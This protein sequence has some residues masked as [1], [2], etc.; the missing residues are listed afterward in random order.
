M[1]LAIA[2]FLAL[3]AFLFPHA[4][5]ANCNSLLDPHFTWASN[6]SGVVVA[7]FTR[8]LQNGYVTYGSSGVGGGLSYDS[9]TDTLRSWSTA[10]YVVD[11]DEMLTCSDPYQPFSLAH[12]KSLSFVVHRN[13]DVELMIDGSQVN[14]SAPTCRDG[15][16]YGWGSFS[17]GFFSL[18]FSNGSL[19]N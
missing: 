14:I 9:A 16:L 12:R 13:G 7:K 17:T 15:V 11:S 5:S 6:G 3:A 8:V 19:I 18:T 1:R 2:A 4:A 10:D